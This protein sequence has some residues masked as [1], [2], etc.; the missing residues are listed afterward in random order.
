LAASEP[1]PG[2]TQFTPHVSAA[3]VNSDGPVQPIADGI[4]NVSPRAV[5]VTFSS[6]SVLVFHRDHRM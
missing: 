4:G 2:P 6:A 5:T 3:Y 1:R